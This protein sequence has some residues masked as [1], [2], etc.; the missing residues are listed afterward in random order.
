[1]KTI[2]AKGRPDALALT[3]AQ[4]VQGEKELEVLLDNPVLGS[5]VASF[6]ESREFSLQIK[7]D[8]GLITVIASKNDNHQP[9][10]SEAEAA[11]SQTELPQAEQSQSEQSRTEQPEATQPRTPQTEIAQLVAVPEVIQ[12]VTQQEDVQPQ[13]AQRSEFPYVPAS[14]FSV[15]ITRSTLGQSEPPGGALMRSFLA[16]LSGL[17]QPPAVVALMN[18]AVLLTLYDSSSCDHLKNLEKKGSSVLISGFCADHFQIAEKIGV[19]T[20]TNTTEIT[21]ALSRSGKVITL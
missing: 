6:L 7:D 16:A 20:L 10:A 13:T 21:E 1:M 12:E 11:Q 18:E 3:K 9:D 17:S 15:L 2:N 19:G 4:V 14:P 8:D 5:E